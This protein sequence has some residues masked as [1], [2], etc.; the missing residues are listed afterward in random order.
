MC[1]KAS[2]L[3]ECSSTVCGFVRSL[4]C[5]ITKAPPK[6]LIAQRRGAGQ[7][8]VL[9][10][11]SWQ[12]ITGFK[13]EFCKLPAVP[14][15]SRGAGGWTLRQWER[16]PRVEAEPRRGRGGL[17]VALS[18]PSRNPGSSSACHTAIPHRDRP[19]AP[20][21]DSLILP[22]GLLHPRGGGNLQSQRLPRARAERTDQVCAAPRGVRPPLRRGALDSP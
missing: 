20:C 12:H 6:D 4:L 19:I 1:L 22:R 16:R 10:C 2:G 3:Q 9:P 5:G 11:I 14:R 7:G 21:P 15:P 18:L 13:A 8:R 17:K